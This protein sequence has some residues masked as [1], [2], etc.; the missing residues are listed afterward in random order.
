MNKVWY[1]CQECKEEF[2]VEQ[3]SRRKYCDKCGWTRVKEGVKKVTHKE[4]NNDN[5]N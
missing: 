5:N 1:I 2:E 4:G 3:G